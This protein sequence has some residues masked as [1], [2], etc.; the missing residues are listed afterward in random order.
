MST[1]THTET[2]APPASLAAAA[3]A[4]A[5]GHGH[6]AHGGADFVPHV[7][8]L[9][10]YLATWITLL[11]LTIATVAASY[12]NFG[13]GNFIIAIL[14][15]T[16]KACVVAAMFMHL[17]YDKKFHAIIFSFSLV[18]LAIFIL[19]TMYD[20]ETRGKTDAVEH[21][22]PV[23]VSTPFKQGKDEVKL[24]ARYEG[25]PAEGAAPEAPKP[26]AKPLAPP[27]G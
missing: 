11:V 3:A 25:T 16:I 17:R 20:T 23:D 12:F 6:G 10:I 27:Q 9:G 8:P 4:D 18:F 26:P 15:A 1:S 21:D 22:R 14:I 13:A 5:H 24:K 7:L 19:F 2:N